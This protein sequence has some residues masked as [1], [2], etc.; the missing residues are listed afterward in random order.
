MKK[1]PKL[2]QCD[3]RGQIVIPKEVRQDLGI[4]EGAGFYMFIVTNE[5]ILLK[6]VEEATLEKDDDI[7]QKIN[8]K[9]TKIGVKKENVDKTITSY[10][11]TKKGGLDLI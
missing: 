11:K 4:E 9:A 10:K 7:I 3:K 2:V 8:E 1:Y 6:K 5:G